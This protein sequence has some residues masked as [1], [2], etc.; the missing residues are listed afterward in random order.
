[1]NKLEPAKAQ[2][3]FTL[4]VVAPDGKVRYE[5]PV[6]AEIPEQPGKESHGT[7]PHDNG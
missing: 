5:I 6:T 4:K 1:M 3:S 2:V 7:D